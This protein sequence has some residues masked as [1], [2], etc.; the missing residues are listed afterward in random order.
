MLAMA[1]IAVACSQTAPQLAGPAETRS[2]AVSDA[3]AVAS[4]ATPPAASAPRVLSPV[5]SASPPEVV[6]RKPETAPTPAPTPTPEPPAP[7]RSGSSLVIVDAHDEPPDRDLFALA[8]RLGGAEGG[9]AQSRTVNPQ[10]VEYYVGHQQSF[11]VTNLSTNETYETVAT[12]RFV[13]D[14]A[15]WYVDDQAEVLEDD[16]VRASEAFEGNIRPVLTNA[17][18]DI[19]TPDVDNDPRL[20]ILNTPLSGGV[21]GY[22]GSQDEY[23]RATHPHS[24]EREMIYMNIGSLKMGSPAYMSVLAH[25]FQHAV[26]WNTDAGED[27]WINEGLSEIANELVGNTSFFVNIFLRNQGKQLNFW[28]DIP[29]A[30]GPYYGGATLFLTYLAQHYGGYEGLRRLA[31]IEL[32]GINGIDEYLSPYG[33][34][35]EDV[36]KD[37]VIANYLDTAEGPYS[38]PDRAVKVQDLDILLTYG[39]NAGI[40]PQFS[41]R[42]VDLRLESGDALVSFQGNPRVRQV[43]TTCRSG[44]LCWWGNV[45]DSIDSTLTREF[46]LTSVE[47]ATLEFWT[48]YDIE[49]DWDYAYVEA[50][51]DGGKT[52][53]ILEGANTT[54]DN[55]V[56]NS[57]GAAWTGRSGEWTRESID[58]SDYAG[59]RVL[60]RFEYITD[61]AVNLDG[62]VFDDIAVPEIDYFDDVEGPSDWLAEGFQRIDNELPQNFVVQVIEIALDGSFS[63]RELTLDE[64]RGGELLVRGFGTRLENAVVVVTPVTRHTYQPATYELTVSPRP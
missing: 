62:I 44:R 27:A 61:D 8:L 55:P 29:G 13:G 37:W 23:P 22:F 19:W 39:E 5:P 34:S 45:G 36:F 60:V 2:D 20:T 3:P 64:E 59:A 54:L 56:G 12:L 31:E 9:G 4:P 58:L 21:L 35:F 17:F 51:R 11:F 41:A 42:Y 16:L 47:E 25:E 48:W 32:D 6:V 1:A 26:H 7:P 50:S 15:Y 52:W 38:Y 33:V 14:H 46:D 53:D 18:R 28:P 49:E 63:V 43:G 57:Y 30:T 24:N 40:L 10:G